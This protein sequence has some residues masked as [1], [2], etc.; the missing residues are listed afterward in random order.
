MTGAFPAPANGKHKTN[1]KR[2]SPSLASGGVTTDI[3]RD[4]AYAPQMPPIEIAVKW[5]SSAVVGTRHST[6]LGAVIALVHAGLGDQEIFDAVI[7][8][9]LKSVASDR[10]AA[11]TTRVV[12]NAVQW[13]RR[14]IGASLDSLDE[15]LN[16]EDWSIWS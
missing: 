5:V 4:M 11:Q 12:Q 8:A 6:M 3:M 2:G 7:D 1:P 14:R 15:D 13:A 16:V 10:P 9:H